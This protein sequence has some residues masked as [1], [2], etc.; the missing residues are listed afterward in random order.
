MAAMAMA[1]K[2]VAVAVMGFFFVYCVIILIADNY[3]RK[4]KGERNEEEW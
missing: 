2:L 4:H 1:A 3:Y